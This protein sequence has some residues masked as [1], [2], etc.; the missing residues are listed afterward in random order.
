MSRFILAVFATFGLFVFAGSRSHSATYF[1]AVDGD[2]SDAGSIEKPFATLMKAQESA[3]PGDT[4]FIRGG[5]YLVSESRVAKSTRW[6]AHVL[7]FDKSG[8]SAEPIRYWAYEDERPVFDFADVR[9]RNQ[10]VHAFSVSGSWLHF[11]GIEVVGVQ[12][13]MRGHTQSICFSN[14]GDHNV[15]ERLGMH[16][17]MAIGFYATKGADNLIVNCDAYRNHD[18]VSEDGRGGNTDGF[19]YHPAKGGTGNVFRGCRAWFNSDDGF[20]CINA[21]ESVAFENCWAFNNGY[22]PEFKSLAD[23][24]GFKIGGFASAPAS[25][26]PRPMPRHLVKECLAVHNKNGGFYANHH[27]G[28]SDWIN[29]VAYRNGTNFNMLCRTHDNSKDVPGYGHLLRGNVSHGS[30]GLIRNLNADKC[31]LIDNTFQVE[32]SLR[33]EDFASLDEQELLQ[34]R[35]ANGE[36]PNIDLLR[37]N[38]S[39]PIEDN[40]SRATE[41]DTTTSTQE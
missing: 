16:D 18:S 29:N 39:A 23:G 30:R 22:S 10:R 4:V 11:R 17:G 27:P 14:E 8:R 20:D 33:D 32:R 13:T 25:K 1:V 24:N 26:L 37:L 12:V 34:P 31:E 28:G 19:G 5:T 15:F 3:E 9:P 38:V 2:D 41:V 7:R 21:S 35:Q 40:V 6:F 36:L